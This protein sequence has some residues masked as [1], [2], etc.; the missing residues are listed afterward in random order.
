MRG[1]NR[2]VKTN[3]G[4][5]AEAQVTGNGKWPRAG[6]EELERFKQS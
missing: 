5:K 4:T 6:A 1:K 2:Y 3:G